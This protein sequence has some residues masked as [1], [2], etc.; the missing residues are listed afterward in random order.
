MFFSGIASSLFNQEFGSSN[1]LFFAHLLVFICV[2]VLLWQFD[3]LKVTGVARFGDYKIW[4]IVIAGTVYFTIAS[5]YSF[6]D[7]IS[8]DLSN[9][10]EFPTSLSIIKTNT[11]V[12]LNEEILFRGAVLFI[13]IQSWG[14]TKKGK[15]GSVILT[16]GIFALLHIYQVFAYGLSGTSALFVPLETFII[17][18]WWAFL[19][20]VGK[21]I[22]PAFI[23]HFVVNTVLAIEGI[24]QSIIQP[25]FHAYYKIFLFS[26]PLGIIG[27]WGI[28][29]LPTNKK[30][31]HNLAKSQD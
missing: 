17:S 15:I 5:L 22:W 19:V 30:N 3:W 14:N 11:A 8:F 9:L 25:D 20:L 18:I 7:K 6:Y 24:S 23:A 29:R 2:L 21:S 10:K 31:N 26:I 4:L 16:S 13:L 1:T 28:L 27:V 12:C